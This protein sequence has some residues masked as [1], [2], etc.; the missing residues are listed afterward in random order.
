MP[1]RS[2]YLFKEVEIGGA[3][4]GVIIEK[5]KPLWKLIEGLKRI[6]K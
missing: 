4:K 5:V 6:P 1:K 3:E 2:Q